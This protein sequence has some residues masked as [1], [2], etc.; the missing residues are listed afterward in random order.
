MKIKEFFEEAA[1]TYKYA[2]AQNEL[3]KLYFQNKIYPDEKPKNKL[4]AF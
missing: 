4:M 1:T 2:E 3:G